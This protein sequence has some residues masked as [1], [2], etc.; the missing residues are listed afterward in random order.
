MDFAHTLRLL[1]KRAGHDK[2]RGFHSYLSEQGVEINY[3]YY[4]KMES[5]QV[6]PSHK[7][8]EQISKSL[9][10]EDGAA[11]VLA[12]C[13]S[14]FPSSRHLFPA[15][16]N[17]PQLKEAK[18]EAA[19][20]VAGPDRG[21]ELNR[22]QVHMLA[23]SKTHYHLFLTATLARKPLAVEELKRV[24]NWKHLQPAIQELEA[25]KVVR[26]LPEGLKTYSTEH[27]FPSATDFPE[28]KPLYRQFDEWD[29]SFAEDF[30]FD[31]RL[32]KML[33]RRISPRYLN[34]IEKSLDT[35]LS[36]VRASDEL[37]DK[38]NEDL[39]QIRLSLKSGRLPG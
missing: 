14:Q 5:G 19:S 17:A 16:E 6:L 31:S 26:L 33:I 9:P 28:L 38:H 3:A 29:E 36:L 24:F 12:Y 30:E 13:R 20:V 21:R 4:M 1:R 32:D 2:A 11:L 8:V 39:I 10:D 27:Q 35:V 37:E 25:A 7:V 15:P 22:R 23:R 18:R 34:V